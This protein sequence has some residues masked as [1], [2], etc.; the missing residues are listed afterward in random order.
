MRAKVWKDL[1]M[2][3]I[4]DFLG[5]GKIKHSP[6]KKAVR[7]AV[8]LILCYVA[9]GAFFLIY[10]FGFGKLYIDHGMGEVALPLLFAASSTA[11]LFTSLLKTNSYLIGAKDYEML[12][13][14][15]IP[16][17]TIVSCR[18]FVTYCI[19]FLFGAA[20][21]LPTGIYYGITFGKTISFYS[22]LFLSLLFLPVFPIIV[23]AVLGVLLM[24][25]SSRFRHKNIAMIFGSILLLIGV[26]SVFLNMVSSTLLYLGISAV[27]MALFYLIMQKTYQF[28]NTSL[29]AHSVRS[30]YKIQGLKTRS[31]FQALFRK[32]WKRY[33]ASPLYVM[34]TAVGYLLMIIL[35]AFLFFSGE[36]SIEKIITIPNIADTITSTLPF[37]L[38][39][40]SAM[41]CSTAVSISIEGKNFWQTVSLPVKPSMIYNSKRA[42]H[43]VFAIPAIFLSC[44]LIALKIPFDPLSLFFLFAVPLSYSFFT[45]ELGLIL[46]IRFPKFD[47]KNETAIVK[48]GLPVSL[49]VFGGMFL[50][51][52]PIFAMFSV[53]ESFRTFISLAITLFL[54][55]TALI[56]HHR[57]N[58]IEL[59]Q[60]SE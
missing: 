44:T 28:L 24:A 14:L 56:L 38:G 46:N 8:L 30:D 11:V 1:A 42:I 50:G 15:P 43:F 27:C 20:L 33:I 39:M 6:D 40:L 32:E 16:T 13:A 52:A 49:C 4:S 35:G 48:Q 36:D 55:V 41:C 29:L 45:A 31:V 10:S 17:A 60:I 5:L 19:E 22:F 3:Q 53:S 47:W 18:L 25:I 2:I 21:L 51:L 57:I 37:I 26:E 58:K 23:S 7:N 59:V 54:S 12:Q 34:N 9:L